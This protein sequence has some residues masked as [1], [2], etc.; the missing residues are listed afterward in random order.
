MASDGNTLKPVASTT[1]ISSPDSSN[2]T[3]TVGP[4][5]KKSKKDSQSRRKSSTK[6]SSYV[7]SEEKKKESKEEKKSSIRKSRSHNDLQK[8]KRSDNDE[9]PVEKF[10]DLVSELS[11]Y[12]INQLQGLQLSAQ[13]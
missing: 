9:E 3:L 5:R 4:Q 7:S 13:L 2:S 6:T 8:M 11:S 10:P 12:E 1:S